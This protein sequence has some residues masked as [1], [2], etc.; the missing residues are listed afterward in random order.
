MAI[1]TRRLLRFKIV[2]AVADYN[3]C[4]AIDVGFK[5]TVTVMPVARLISR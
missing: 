5:G 2:N 4:F 1:P 3:A